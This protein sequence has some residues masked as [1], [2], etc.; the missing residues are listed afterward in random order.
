MKTIGK[1]L[2]LDNQ[3]EPENVFLH[4]IPTVFGLKLWQK[5]HV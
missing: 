4:F 5:G 2:G 1:C 3:K